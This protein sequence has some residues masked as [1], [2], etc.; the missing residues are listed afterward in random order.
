MSRGTMPAPM[1]PSPINPMFIH[2]PCKRRDRVAMRSDRFHLLAAVAIGPQR[3]VAVH[4]DIEVV[5][6]RIDCPI[7]GIEPVAGPLE[8]RPI[9]FGPK[10]LDHLV[11]VLDLEA[12]MVKARRLAVDLVGVDR[13]VEIA[14]GE[15]DA[16]VLGTVLHRQSHDLDVEL[17]QPLDVGGVKDDMTDLGH[18][19]SVARLMSALPQAIAPHRMTLS[20]HQRAKAAAKGWVKDG[21]MLKLAATALFAVLALATPA[22]SQALAELYHGKQIKLIVG[23]ATGQDYDLWARLIGRH[24]TRHIPGNPSLIVENMPGAGHIVA[25]NHLYNVAARDG[26]VLGMVSRNMTDAAV[27]GLANV[28]YDPGRFNW[29]GSPEINHRV[30]FVSATS[31]FETVADLFMRELIVGAPGGVQGVTAAPLLLKNLLG[32]KL[33]IVQGYRSP[34]DVVLAVTRGEVGGFVNSVGGPVGARRQWVETGQ[35]RILFNMEPEAVPWLGAPTIFDYLK[36]DE[37]RAVLTFFSGNTQLGRPLMAPPGVPA[38]RVDAL[39]QAFDATMREPAFLKEAE[40]MGFEVAPQNGERIAALVA[41]ALATP[42]DI[43][44]LAERA[45]QSE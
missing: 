27:M 8:W 15:G 41:S 9:A 34:G 26:T 44:K 5:A 2:S 24:I 12:E 31:G 17:H 43:V 33:K 25:T 35:M 22:H 14:V 7:L 21:P 19:S 6:V 40:G 20:F 10:A 30:M 23:T 3:V 38:D 11:V 39:R 36:T 45:T 32:M 13:E 28:R 16:A 1:A 42:K 29:L 4:R 18:G 37:Q